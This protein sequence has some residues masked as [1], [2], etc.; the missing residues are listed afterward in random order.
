MRAPTLNYSYC[1]AVFAKFQIKIV[2][3]PVR[4]E[5]PHGQEHKY[6]EGLRFRG[7]FI[8]DGD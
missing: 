6:I 4:G 3:N 8:D 5:D 1:N 7:N 2:D